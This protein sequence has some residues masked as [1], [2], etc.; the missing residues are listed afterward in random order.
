METQSASNQHDFDLT[1]LAEKWFAELFDALVDD[2]PEMLDYITFDVRAFGSFAI[3][4]VYDYQCKRQWGD[5]SSHTAQIVNYDARG[6]RKLIKN[7]S[8]I[9]LGTK[10]RSTFK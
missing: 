5:V 10:F 6:I 8:K 4:H 9:R 2:M 1:P 3:R 7:K